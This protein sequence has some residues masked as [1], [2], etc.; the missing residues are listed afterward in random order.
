MIVLL[1]LATAAAEPGAYFIS[2]EIT[3]PAVIP[4]I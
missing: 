2:D 1:L 3:D 4:C